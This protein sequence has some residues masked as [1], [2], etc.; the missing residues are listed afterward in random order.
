[1]RVP[2]VLAVQQRWADGRPLVSRVS[3]I[4]NLVQEESVYEESGDAGPAARPQGIR[5][6]HILHVEAALL[7]H[8]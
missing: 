2:P 1:V 3:S 8:R 6:Q 5:S 4:G 7:E